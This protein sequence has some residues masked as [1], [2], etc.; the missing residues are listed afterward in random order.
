MKMSYGQ[1]EWHINEH[2]PTNILYTYSSIYQQQLDT[3]YTY[4]PEK[5]GMQRA[6]KKSS[7]VFQFPGSK[8]II[9]SGLKSPWS[10]GQLFL[11]DHCFIASFPYG[12]WQSGAELSQN[13]S[14]LKLFKT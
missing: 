10:V 14:S 11:Q 7:N 4:N 12:L 13:I 8:W 5:K 9:S 3:F 1:I 6:N 2:K